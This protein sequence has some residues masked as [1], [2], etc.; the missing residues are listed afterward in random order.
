MIGKKITS[1]LLI[2][3]IVIAPFTGNCIHS[4]LFKHKPLRSEAEHECRFICLRHTALGY[5]TCHPI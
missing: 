4:F 2:L 3:S 1:V 5:C